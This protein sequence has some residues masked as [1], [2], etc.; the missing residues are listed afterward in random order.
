[1]IEVLFVDDELDTLQL[2]K[3]K[4][5]GETSA[6]GVTIATAANA[7]ECLTY[8]EN[9]GECSRVLV[10][11]DLSM[12]EMDGIAL[13]KVIQKRFP[14]VKVYIC[15]AFDTPFLRKNSAEKGAL[16]FFTKPLDFKALRLAMLED[17]AVEFAAKDSAK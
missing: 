15:T 11:S 5:E 6:D 13:L 16:R 17:F 1:M 14:Q 7:Q 12:P 8:L 9:R 2:A 10:V 4:F 3:V